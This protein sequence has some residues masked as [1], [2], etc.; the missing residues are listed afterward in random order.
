MKPGNSAKGFLEEFLGNDRYKVAKRVPESKNTVFND[1]YDRQDYNAILKEMKELSIAEDRLSEVVSTGTPA[2][3]DTYFSLVKAVPKLKDTNNIRPSHMINR[4]VMG[5]AMDL[6]EYEELRVYSTNDMVASGLACVSMEP[7]LEIL[8]DKLKQEEKLASELEEQMM[9]MQGMSDDLESLDDMAASAMAQGEEGEAKNYQEQAEKIKEQM[10]KL[11]EQMQQKA[12]ELDDG[13]EQ[14]VP[15]LKEMTKEALKKAKEKAQELDSLSSTWGLDPGTLSKMP[16]QRRIELASKFNNEKFRRIADLLG[17][18]QRLALAEQKRKVQ[19]ARDEI[20]DLEL[21][22]DLPNVLP[23]EILALGD[24]TMS[25]DF[26]RRYT[27]RS[28]LQYKLRGSEKIAKGGIYWCEDGSGS[29]HGEPEIWG[30]AVG[31]SLYK[32]AQMQ[33]REFYGIHFGSPGEYQTFDFHITNGEGVDIELYGKP[34]KSDGNTTGHYSTLD[35]V[36]KFAETF[37][38]SGTDFVTPLSAALDKLRVEFEEF[39][40]VK[41]DIVFCTD[42]ICGV[43][44][45]WLKE[46]KEEQARLGFRT[47]GVLLGYAPHKATEPLNTICDGRVFTLQDLL[48]GDGIRDIF[49]GV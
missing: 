29:M 26:F 36:I 24:E 14:K 15:Q 3:E 1:K 5:E 18:M 46:F 45:S 8:F 16:A 38:N 9:Q 30:K 48:G 49:R 23:T 11:R 32:I 35:G 21:G 40:A 4:A 25:V 44:D 7:E 13:M 27:E 2:M 43:P 41:G 33:K 10:D 19:Y 17:P 42:G 37:F 34:Y 20:Y 12:Q 22:N 31:L 47:W 28:L 39:G 6:K